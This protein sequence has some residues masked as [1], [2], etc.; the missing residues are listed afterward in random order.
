MMEKGFDV[1]IANISGTKYSQVNDK[2]TSADP[3]F[4]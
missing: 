2:Y 3:E 1:Y 4:W